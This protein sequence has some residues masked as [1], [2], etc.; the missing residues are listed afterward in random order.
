MVCLII[1]Y[2]FIQFLAPIRNGIEFNFYET[3]YV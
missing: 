3:Y 2:H 1:S